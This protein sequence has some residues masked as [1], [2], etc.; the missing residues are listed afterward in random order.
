MKNSDFL[1][2]SGSLLLLLFLQLGWSDYMSKNALENTVYRK[3]TCIVVRLK[4]IYIK[5]KKL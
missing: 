2:C 3:K 1:L 5:L 4:Y